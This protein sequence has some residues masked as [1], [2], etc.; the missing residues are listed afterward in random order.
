M[1]QNKYTM[2]RKDREMDRDFALM[3]ADKCEYAHLAM[4]GPDGE[5]YCIPLSIALDGET[6][7]FHCAKEGRKVDALKANPAVC[8]SCVGSTQRA[9]DMFT[10]E[11]ESAVIFGTASEVLEDDEKIHALKLICERHTPANRHAFEAAISKSLDRT[12][13]WKIEIAEITGKKKTL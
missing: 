3:V 9:T 12:A 1:Q 7:Y 2:R 4:T 10:T 6:I 8:M 5:P 13:V 11:F